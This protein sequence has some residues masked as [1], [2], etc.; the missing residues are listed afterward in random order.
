ML[1]EDKFLEWIE[2]VASDFRRH[3]SAMRGVSPDHFPRFMAEHDW[4]RALQ[5]HADGMRADYRSRAPTRPHGCQ[6]SAPPTPA[7]GRAS[8]GAGHS[9]R[10]R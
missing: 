1:Q 9:R 10:G 4:W 7:L 3:R 5:A 2:Q 8:H 6:A